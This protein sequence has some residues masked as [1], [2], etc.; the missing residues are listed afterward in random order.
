MRAGFLERHRLLL[1]SVVSLLLFAVLTGVSTGYRRRYD[2]NVAERYGAGN[3]YAYLSVTVSESSAMTNSDISNYRRAMDS[4]CVTESLSSEGRTWIDCYSGQSTTSVNNPDGTLSASATITVCGGS[5]FLFHEMNFKA[6]SGND[7]GFDEVVIDTELAWKL[8][9]SYNVCGMD[10]FVDGKL[11]R[12]GGVVQ[13]PGGFAEEY[14]ED[15]PH[16]WI[17]ENLAEHLWGEQSYTTYELLMPNPVDG[18]A[19]K[20]FKEAVG[21]GEDRIL[22]EVSSRF[23]TLSLLKSIPEL[24]RSAAHTSTVVCPWWD[25]A[26]RCAAQLCAI[27]MIFQVLAL[28]LPCIYLLHLLILAYRYRKVPLLTLQNKIKQIRNRRKK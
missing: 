9:G 11:C 28:I 2:E 6:G 14:I 13:F 5:W 21:E 20:Y 10:L 4:A 7:G 27:L 25:N 15:T 3:T 23:D 22:S 19:M 26:S 8:F 12:I 1:A 18:L 24:P 17:T 16:I